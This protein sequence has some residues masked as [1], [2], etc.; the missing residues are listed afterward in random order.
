MAH[1]THRVA[2]PNGYTQFTG[3]YEQCLEHVGGKETAGW[4]SIQPLKVPF[5]VPDATSAEL[6]NGSAE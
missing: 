3:S 4:L 5:D 2:G 6:N 1:Y